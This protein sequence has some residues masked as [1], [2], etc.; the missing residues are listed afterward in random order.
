MP[1]C[2][3]DPVDIRQIEELAT[4]HFGQQKFMFTLSMY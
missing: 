3:T 4:L 1:I 2:V